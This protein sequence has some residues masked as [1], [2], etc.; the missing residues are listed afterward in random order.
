MTSRLAILL[1]F[2]CVCAETYGCT[3]RA[4]HEGFRESQRQK[5]YKLPSDDAM[6]QCL[7]KVDKMTYDQY[8]KARKELNNNKTQP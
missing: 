8:K 7:N 3:Y 1:V 6:Q 2:V 5:C 4:W